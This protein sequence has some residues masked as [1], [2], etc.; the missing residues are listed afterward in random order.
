MIEFQRL[1]AL[2]DLSART[3]GSDSKT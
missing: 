2:P 1:E 3:G